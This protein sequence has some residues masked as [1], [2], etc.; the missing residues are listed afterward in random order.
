MQGSSNQNINQ[1]L[2]LFGII[3]QHLSG[4]DEFAEEKCETQSK[5]SDIDAVFA[6]EGC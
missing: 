6:A 2:P 5:I 3:A 1:N 4:F